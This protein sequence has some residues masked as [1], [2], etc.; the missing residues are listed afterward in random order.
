MK[1]GS[2]KAHSL[3][4][5]WLV[6]VGALVASTASCEFFYRL[7]NRP[8]EAGFTVG[9][10]T[11]G[12]APLAVTVSAA[13]SSDPDDNIEDYAWDFGD[14]TTG[15]GA[16]APHTYAAVGTYT[17]VLTVTDKYGETDTATK[18]ISVIPAETGPT[19]SFTAS[20][21][22]GSSPL[23]VAFDASASTYP[24]G[25]IQSYSWEFGDGSYGYGVSVWHTYSTST[26]KSYV[27]KLTVRATDGETASATKTI[28]VSTPGGG[29]TTTGAPSARF[30]IRYEDPAVN[31]DDYTN[32]SVAPVRVWLDPSDSEAASGRTIVSYSWS[33]GDGTASAATTD[34]SQ[35]HRYI[36]SDVS[37]TFSITL[38]VIDD[39]GKTGS[40]TKTVKVEN[41]QPVAGF[42]IYRLRNAGAPFVANSW[43]T[44]SSDADDDDTFLTWTDVPAGVQTVSIRTK[45]L[46]DDPDWD[47]LDMND[48]ADPVPNAK[49][50]KPGGYEDT[51][52]GSEMCFDREGQA[53]DAAGKPAWF[54]NNAWGIQQLEINWGDG[55]T[56]FVPFLGNADTVAQHGYTMGTTTG[57]WTIRVTA[58]D[59]LGAR[60][61]FSRKIRM[62]P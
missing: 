38:V 22:S 59:Y 21:T 57:T 45:A 6:M 34:V 7:L 19:A 1:R 32:K 29:T 41:Y 33:F 17:I 35:V 3:R 46:V 62:Q 50:A 4:L 14:G 58:I 54:P 31:G 56:D 13:T 11:V 43:W 23:T 16:T 47:G 18:T 27:V 15:S 55:T 8:P 26:G 20:P 2:T 28:T 36:T 5:L 30:A 44:E 39:A 42:E 48:Q 60:A 25:T 52:D 10:T 53:W 37:K 12:A 61:S 40:I 51:P 24:D 9:P 49:T